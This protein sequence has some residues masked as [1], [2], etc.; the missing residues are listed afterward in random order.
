[1]AG[2]WV[3]GFIILAIRLALKLPNSAWKGV[4]CLLF[5]ILVKWMKNYACGR[6]VFR[7]KRD[8]VRFG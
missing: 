3:M 7:G 8:Y 6:G 5:D 2:M 1:M 4:I